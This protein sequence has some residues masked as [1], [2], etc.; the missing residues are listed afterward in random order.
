MGRKPRSNHLAIGPGA[1][2][3]PGYDFE[4]RKKM[5]TELKEKRV[6]GRT[7]SQGRTRTLLR[8]ILSA[9]VYQRGLQTAKVSPNT[10]QKQKAKSKLPFPPSC[11]GSC[12]P[13]GGQ[14][15]RGG[16]LIQ[17]SRIP[18]S[19]S[20]NLCRPKINASQRNSYSKNKIR[21]FPL[22][23]HQVSDPLPSP[24]VYNQQNM[25]LCKLKHIQFK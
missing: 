5:W 16:Q 11:L 14:L 15:L 9:M 18:P 22:P 3:K 19:T 1:H 21:T 10:A 23:R 7:S 20:G 4:G 2:P 12:T 25:Q 24:K 6:Q 8:R 13:S 17:V